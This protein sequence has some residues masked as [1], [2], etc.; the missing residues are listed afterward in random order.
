M[1]RRD[2]LVAVAPYYGAEPAFLVERAA[3][4][5]LGC[6]G[7]GGIHSPPSGADPHLHVPIQTRMREITCVHSHARTH[8]H[9][10]MHTY[11]R[12]RTR[13][14][15]RIHNARAARTQMSTHAC[16]CARA[17]A[18]VHVNGYVAAD[19]SGAIGGHWMEGSIKHS[20]GGIWVATRSARKPTWPSTL[21]FLVQVYREHA[22]GE[23]RGLGRI[24]G[25]AL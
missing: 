1:H 23:R 8:M 6:K 13:T 10:H 17:H 5:L 19:D 21:F 22:D 20:I 2:E 18:G 16:K 9:M 4:P 12:A 24:R 7:Y 3:Y 15:A 11:T 25:P 14:H